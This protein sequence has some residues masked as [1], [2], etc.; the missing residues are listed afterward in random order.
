MDKKAVF[1]FLLVI[2][3][4]RFFDYVLASEGLL[5]YIAYGYMSVAVLLSLPFFFSE[6][7]GF[8]LPIQLISTSIFLSI[9]MAQISWGQGLQYAPTTIP[10]LIWFTF[11]YLIHL[12]IPIDKVEKIVLFFGCVYIALFLFQF[13]HS[14]TVLFGFREIVEDRGVNRVVFPGGGV[15]LLSCFIAI[16]KFTTVKKYKYVW[17]LFALSGVAI[18]VL[19][20][21]RQQIFLLVLFYLIHLLKDLK[22]KYKIL[23]IVL[24]ALA[25]YAFLN[26][27]NSISKGLVEQQKTDA[28]FGKD[29]IRIVAAEYFFNSF[30]PNLVSKVFGNGVANDTSSYGKY[31]VYLSETYGFFLT[32][33]GVLELYIMFGIFAILGYIWILIKSFTL[34]LPNQYYYIKYYIWFIMATSLSSDFLISPSYLITTILVLYCYQYLY[35]WPKISLHPTVY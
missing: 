14:S 33:I 22:L 12:K 18:T 10:Y 34:S 11:F 13:T 15:F 31:M 19:Q 23:T 3:S 8:V 28:S 1:L 9:F 35:K 27:E 2:L 7:G 4:L 21:T 16:N 25:S 30:T 6:K 24:F 26:S 32:D 17:L 29:Y 20:V 5:K